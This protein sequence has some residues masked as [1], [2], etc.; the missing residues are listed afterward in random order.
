[1]LRSLSE[2]LSVPVASASAVLA[3]RSARVV[4]LRSP[5]EFAQDHLPGARNVPLFDDLER[6]LIGTL[7]VRRSPEEAFAEGRART[8]AKI[9]ALT[10]DLAREAGR[11]ASEEELE[12]RVDE[13]T[14]GGLRSLEASLVLEPQILVPDGAF[15]LHCWRGGLR[16]RSVVA[17]L[18]RLGWSDVLALEGGYRSYRRLVRERIEGWKAPPCF[19]LRGWTGVG[20]TLVLREIEGLR[21]GWT[22]DLEALAGHRSSILGMVGLEPCTQ[23]TFESRLAARLGDGF[24]AVCVLEGESRRVGEV[25]LPG[26]VWDALDGG[27]NL[28]LVAPTERRV[29]VL[30]EDY[31]ARETNR[32]E[33]ARQLPFIEERLGRAAWQGKLVEQLETGREADLVR[34]L[35]ERYYDPL[36]AHSER[37]RRYSA[38]FEASD[39]ARAAAEIVGWIEGGRS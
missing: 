27:T 25:L 35:L 28:E 30:I 38:R 12:G 10:R 20:K 14:A 11:P 13:L 34:V 29:A 31:L 37:G 8:R 32:S 6:A 16:S 2:R 4:D 5:A 22:L 17:F 19:V 21:P 18:R 23:K 9:R 3:A 24:P 36:Y 7:Y 33:L 1:M 15:V 26:P 39:P